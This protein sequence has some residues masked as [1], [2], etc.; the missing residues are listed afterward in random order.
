[1]ATH[2]C[3]ASLEKCV[4]R[5]PSTPPVPS[6]YRGCLSIKTVKVTL[7][8]IAL[9]KFPQTCFSL[10]WSIEVGMGGNSPQSQ[11]HGFP[12]P[13]DR[14]IIIIHHVLLFPL[15]PATSH[16]APQSENGEDLGYVPSFT[17]LCGQH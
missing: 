16:I 9:P 14:G 11:Y 5:L 1:M 6:P 3:V 10:F 12:R 4:Y 8:E 2:S 17:M 7:K 15:S 13:T